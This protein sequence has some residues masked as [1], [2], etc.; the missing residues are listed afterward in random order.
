MH[1]DNVP[2]ALRAHRV[3][4]RAM[5]LVLPILC[6]TVVPLAAAQ[7]AP[8]DLVGRYRLAEDH[9]AAGELV[10]SADGHF[11]YGLAYGALDE[12]A[13][14]RW[15][16]QGNQIC[17]YTQPRPVP[18]VMSR[19]PAAQAAGQ[20]ATL[21]VVWPD[22]RGI[23]G[24][25][26]RIGFDSGDPVEGYTQEDGFTLSPAEHR[27]PR[28]IELYE[29][30]NR[31]RA[32]RFALDSRDAGKLRVTLTPNDLGMVDF[33]GACLEA[34]GQGVVLHRAEGDMHFTPAGG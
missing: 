22:G 33:E 3:Q 14:G 30:I 17:L 11:D 27:V 32:P 8:P 29:P 28:W 13:H 2:L 31:I 19:T 10:V 15:Q 16:R 18:P 12:E 24:V 25:D 1:A 23:P 7:A 20:A 9:D 21:M 26:F 6:L 5:R 34:A 4:T